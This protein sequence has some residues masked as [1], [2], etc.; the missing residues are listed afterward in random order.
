M[1]LSI[2]PLLAS[3]LSYKKKNCKKNLLI[4]YLD[5]CITPLGHMQ[6]IGVS[7]AHANIQISG[8]GFWVGS[9]ALCSSMKPGGRTRAWG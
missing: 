2:K 8:V 6:H 9:W 7:C 5:T 1:V 3:H 4:L